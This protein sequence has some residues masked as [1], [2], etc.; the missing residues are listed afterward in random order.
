MAEGIPSESEIEHFDKGI[1]VRR[2]YLTEDGTPITDNRFPHGSLVVAEITVKAIEESLDN[3]DVTDVLPAGIEIENPRIESRAG[4]PWIQDQNFTPS[5]IDIR[6]YRF[7][8]FG[9]FKQNLQTKFYYALRAVT[10]GRFALPPVAA[11]AMYDPFKSSVWGS[12][13][14]EVVDADPSPEP[15]K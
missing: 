13:S 2:R 5:Y 8:F 1:Q 12:G 10:E 15:E 3:V 14:I 4:I 7:I 9:Y 11:E 6:V